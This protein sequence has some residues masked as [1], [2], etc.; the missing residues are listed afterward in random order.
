MSP[1]A[2]TIAARAD[3]LLAPLAHAVRLVARESSCEDG[4]N[5]PRCEKPFNSSKIIIITVSITAAV[6]ILGTATVLMFLHMRRERIERK[7]DALDNF[8][9]DGDVD[10]HPTMGKPPASW[11][12]QGQQRQQNPFEPGQQPSQPQENPFE[13]GRR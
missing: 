4:D 3:S 8:E 1:I 6:L 5:S 13:P 10:D 2:N 11:Q 12:R 7:E 9:L